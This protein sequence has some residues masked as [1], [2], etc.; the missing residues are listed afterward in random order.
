MNIINAEKKINEVINKKSCIV[1]RK[2]NSGVGRTG[3]A[4]RYKYGINQGRFPIKSCKLL[5]KIIISLKKQIEIL[6][7]IL[8]MLERA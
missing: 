5:Q 6:H 8:F 7:V 3:S 4:K 2:H 1:F